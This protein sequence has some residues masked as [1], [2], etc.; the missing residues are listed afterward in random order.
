MGKLINKSFLFLILFKIIVAFIISLF[1]FF[2]SMDTRVLLAVILLAV[3]FGVFLQFRYKAQ[4]RRYLSWVLSDIF[5]LPAYIPIVKECHTSSII[6]LF[7]WE[8]DFI[9]IAFSYV[10]V[11]FVSF[12]IM[13]FFT[14]YKDAS[15]YVKDVLDDEGNVVAEEKIKNRDGENFREVRVN[16]KID[17]F[18]LIIGFI[19]LIIVLQIKYGIFFRLRSALLG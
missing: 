14:S 6:D 3:P 9:I 8:F 12:G 11:E 13:K 18:W 5:A 7:G 10:L 4:Y 19:L 16:K 2:T 1:I 15:I 17:I